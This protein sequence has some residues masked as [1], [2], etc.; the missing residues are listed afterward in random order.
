MQRSEDGCDMRRFRSFNHSTCKTVRSESKIR[1]GSPTGS[2]KTMEERIFVKVISDERA[3]AEGEMDGDQQF[4][5]Q[6]RV[7]KLTS[8]LK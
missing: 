5:T 8:S 6:D 7:E 2:R 4:D 1:E 3:K